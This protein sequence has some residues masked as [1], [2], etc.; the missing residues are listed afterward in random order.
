MTAEIGVILMWMT[1]SSSTNTSDVPG[2]S[3]PC[4]CRITGAGSGVAGAFSSTPTASVTTSLCWAATS[5][6]SSA[7]STLL[8]SLVLTSE[9][10]LIMFLVLLLRT[11]VTETSKSS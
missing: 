7:A 6:A 4:W 2:K 1:S 8:A 10:K 9:T 5:P 3:G 11:K